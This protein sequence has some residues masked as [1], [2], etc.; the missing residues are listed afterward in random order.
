MKSFNVS[1]GPPDSVAWIAACAGNACGAGGDDAQQRPRGDRRLTG[2]LAKQ[3]FP[4]CPTNAIGLGPPSGRCG[5]HDPCD[6][7][8]EAA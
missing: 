6:S 5:V 4:N 1:P 8:R 2:L 7:Q 3:V